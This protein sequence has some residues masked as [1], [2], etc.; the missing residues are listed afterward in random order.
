MEVDISGIKMERRARWTK[1][2]VCRPP[3]R[4]PPGWELQ[5][6][7]AHAGFRNRDESVDGMRDSKPLIECDVWSLVVT[8]ARLSRD[9]KLVAHGVSGLA[10]VPRFSCAREVE[11]WAGGLGRQ[12]R[13]PFERSSNLGR[14]E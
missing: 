13:G 4:V 2:R 5:Q 1:L 12:D 3:V 14:E 7:F 11:V 9:V 8:P 6:L 10:Y